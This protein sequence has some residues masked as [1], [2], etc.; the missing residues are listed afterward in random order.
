MK[1]TMMV[2]MIPILVTLVGIVIVVSD[3]QSLKALAPKL[4]VT[5]MM[6]TVMMMMKIP[7]DVTIVAIVTIGRQQPIPDDDVHTIASDDNNEKGSSSGS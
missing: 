2:I 1:I 7:I 6:M 3:V 4:M 5:M